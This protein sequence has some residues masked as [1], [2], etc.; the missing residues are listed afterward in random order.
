MRKIT[1]AEGAQWLLN[2]LDDRGA[3]LKELVHI[4]Y[5]LGGKLVLCSIN[6][7]GRNK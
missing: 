4:L 6:N 3:S 5:L 2:K 7:K 1:D